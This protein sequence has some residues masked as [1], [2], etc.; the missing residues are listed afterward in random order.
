MRSYMSK[1]E[2]LL[3]L[4][5]AIFPPMCYHAAMQKRS[6]AVNVVRMVTALF[7]SFM[8]L[9]CMTPNKLMKKASLLAVN[10]REGTI[11][12]ALGTP[13]RIEFRGGETARLYCATGL[14]HNAYVVVMLEPDVVESLTAWRTIRPQYDCSND[15]AF[16]P[17][18][19]QQQQ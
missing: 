5:V 11:D 13:M 1:H 8:F 18:W 9:G 7:S 3:Y 17:I 10:D 15:P 6:N 16:K 14:D 4:H 2:S 12:A 19:R